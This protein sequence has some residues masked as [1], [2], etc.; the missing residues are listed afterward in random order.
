M[1]YIALLFF[2]KTYQQGIEDVIR[3]FEKIVPLNQLIIEKYIIDGSKEST[4]IALQDF[5]DKFPNGKRTTISINTNILIDITDYLKDKGLENQIPSFS[6]NASSNIIKSLENVLTY[7]PYE[8]FSVMSHMMVFREYRMKGFHILF[9]MDTVDDVYYQNYIQL[10][11]HQCE[12]LN[13]PYKIGTLEKNKNYYFNHETVILLLASSQSLQNIYITPFFLQQIPKGCYIALSPATTDINDIFNKVP[14]YAIIPTP[15][16]YTS[17]SQSVYDSVVDKK[18]IFYGCYCFFD[19]LFTL[20]FIADLDTISI[21]IYISANPW[22]LINPAFGSI[23]FDFTINGYNYGLYDMIFTKDSVIGKDL[24]LYNQY[25][26]GGLARTPDS[27]SV[28]RTIGIVPY[29]STKIFYCH[30]DYF[31]FFNEKEKLEFTRFDK[32]TTIYKNKKIAI[33][34]AIPCQFSV[35]FNSDGFFKELINL[36]NIGID[37]VKVNM[38]MSKRIICKSV[39]F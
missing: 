37:N 1:I 39:L 16:D 22:T 19:I 6:L 30:E 2:L 27:Q 4:I 15:I 18:N 12:L 33:S 35:S 20:N 28:F 3:F 17:T 32:S 25:N 26:D 8:Q 36:P 23:A 24:E 31:K 34:E 21:L 5:L 11:K 10:M 29:F 9:E 13:I 14:A 7:G 38:T